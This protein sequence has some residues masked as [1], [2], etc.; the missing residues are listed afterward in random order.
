MNRFLVTLLLACCPSVFLH[1]ESPRA[2][3]TWTDATGRTLQAALFGFDS[4]QV[5]LQF[6]DGRTLRLQ[7]AQLSEADRHFIMRHIAEVF[8][9]I[10]GKEVPMSG[11]LVKHEEMS[12]TAGRSWPHSLTATKSLLFARPAGFDSERRCNKF[13]TRRFEYLLHNGVGISDEL[14]RVFE[15]TYELLRASPWGIQARP[16]NDFFR[17]EVFARMEDYHA[18]G[19]PE[20]SAGVYLINER[21]FM[22]PLQSLGLMLPPGYR[23]V[24]PSR[25]M[26][27]LIHEMT[28]MM[29]H[30]VLDLLPMWFIEGSAEYTSC[31][32]YLE[33][34]FSPPKV[35]EGVLRRVSPVF[36]PG[37]TIPRSPV[38]LLAYDELLNINKRQWH[39]YAITGVVSPG[40]G[41]KV[42]PVGPAD[43]S[44]MES[45]YS[46]SLLLTYYF[47]N[48]EGDRKGTRLLQYLEAV[49]K[50]QP[51][52]NAWREEVFRYLTAKEE[53]M[54]RPEVKTKPDGTI[55]FPGFLTPPAEPV[56]PRPEYATGEVF[57]IHLPILLNGKT[58][59]Q[60]AED[61]AKAVSLD[62]IV[63]YR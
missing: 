62:G 60:L 2:V 15:G 13:R 1:G 35:K 49:R 5:V 61:V 54:K 9:P 41:P 32:P 43:N 52:W 11:A 21:I 38:A 17:V 44:R 6:P 18:G 33:G 22:L 50:E 53:F 58:P 16:D 23:L 10:S 59:A 4:G 63:T 48:L 14:A 57:K 29:M 37:S 45:L 51:R 24:D 7:A 46:T 55:T 3:R 40:A 42:M 30:D 39:E 12:F 31:I 20:G 34:T 25:Q 36:R 28:H 47:M 8:D 19:G 27:T 56:P 26:A